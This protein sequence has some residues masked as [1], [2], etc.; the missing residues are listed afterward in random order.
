MKKKTIGFFA[1]ALIV[2]FS[3]ITL[4]VDRVE[5][6]VFSP[7]RNPF[8][9]PITV[10]ID[11]KYVASDVQPVMQYNR[12]ML[13][14][15]AAAEALGAD[16][17]WDNQSRC[18]T[19]QKNGT[20]TYF[21]VGNTLYYQ[22]GAAKISDVAPMILND[23]TM[24]PI[25]IF[26]EALDAGVTWDGQMLDVKIDT[27]APD[28]QPPAMPSALPS[29]LHPLIQKYYVEPTKQGLGTWYCVTPDNGETY[30]EVLSIYELPDG[31]RHAVEFFGKD[32]RR[33]GIS[34]FVDL[35]SDP[36]TSHGSGCVLH[37]AGNDSTFYQSDTFLGLTFTVPS[38]DYFTYDNGSTDILRIYRDNPNIVFPYTTCRFKQIS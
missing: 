3:L 38:N 34:D 25:R 18:I 11:G 2:A 23:R 4:P 22:D 1:G 27:P 30:Y 36:V 9:T 24:L 37:R 19:V 13:P 10:H 16:V 17:Y 7:E 35:Y 28:N 29:N 21:Y 20:T 15:H 6:A 31:T 14:M 32:I 26:A 33:L 5:A 8:G 12:V